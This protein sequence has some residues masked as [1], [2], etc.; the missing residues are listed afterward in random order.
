MPFG[1]AVGT[2]LDRPFSGTE[3]DGIPVRLFG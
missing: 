1:E 3:R 2:E